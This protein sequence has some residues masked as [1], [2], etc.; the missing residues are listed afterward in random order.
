M[1]APRPRLH[2][3]ALSL[4][5]AVLVAGS[6]GCGGPAA[7]EDAAA[8]AGIAF[9]AAVASGDHA[10]ACALLAP[11]TREQLEQDEHKNCPA[12]LAS[13]DLPRARGVR[14][15]EAYGRQAV[16]RMSGDTMFLS[17][18]PAGWRVVAAGCAPRPERP[19]NCLIKG[20]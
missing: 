5:A 13:Q 19:Y 12:A 10:H 14:E 4:A 1:T 20:A 7:R 6:A 16:V 17:Q 11:Q 9:E 15:A 3:Y 8:T 2:R 18:F